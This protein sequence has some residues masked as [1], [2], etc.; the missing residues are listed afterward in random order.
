M[1]QQINEVKRMQQLAGLINEENINRMSSMQLVRNLDRKTIDK[2]NN[3][4]IEF[5]NHKFHLTDNSKWKPFEKDLQGTY[6]LS[7]SG[8]DDDLLTNELDNL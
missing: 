4:K 6:T 3:L 5:P 1:K 7:V 8:P 2:I